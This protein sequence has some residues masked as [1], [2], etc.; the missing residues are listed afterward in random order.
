[1][2]VS[3]EMMDMDMSE[4]RVG[5]GGR[6]GHAPFVYR[7]RVRFGDSDA[8]QIIYV[9]RLFDYAM[10]A[11]EGWF[12]QIAGHDWYVIN[13]QRD[14]GTPFV[15]TTMNVRSALKPGDYVNVAVFVVSAGRSSIRFAVVGR[16]DSGEVAFES[17]WVCA[18]T[19]TR[20]MQSMDIP[21]DLRRTIESYQAQCTAP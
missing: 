11:M 16:R 12:S 3:A 5:N 2:K 13:T 14:M 8:A 7:R 4:N 10:E 9:V 6:E 18:V 19:D 1:M 20:N 21:T 17:E 15:H